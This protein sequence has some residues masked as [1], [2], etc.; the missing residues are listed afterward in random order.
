MVENRLLGEFMLDP[1]LEFGC[2]VAEWA[3]IG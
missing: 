2:R 3:G 1:A